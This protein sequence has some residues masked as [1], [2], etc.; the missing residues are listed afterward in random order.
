MAAI[1][2]SIYGVGLARHNSYMHQSVRLAAEAVL[3]AEIPSVI[4][5]DISRRLAPREIPPNGN[6]YDTWFNK[7]KGLFQPKTGALGSAPK[8]QVPSGSSKL[9]RHSS[10]PE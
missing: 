10:A 7:N 3:D 1:P 4:T 6:F 5:K 8:T 2:I 9:G